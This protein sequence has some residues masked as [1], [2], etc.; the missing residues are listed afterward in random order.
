MN[1]EMTRK[2]AAIWQHSGDALVLADVE[3]QRILDANP[4]AE[5]LFGYSC[6]Q[7]QN[8]CVRDIHPADRLHEVMAAF[9]EG[10]ANPGHFIDLEIRRSDGTRV[11]V[12]INTGTFVGDDGRLIGIG[13][14][15]DI[16]ERLRAEHGVQR[17]N[18]ALT[19]INRAA[20][21]V[22]T[23][24][25]ETEMMRQ[26]CAALTDDVFVLSW[27]ALAKDNP[28]APVTIA[29]K[30]GTALGYLDGIEISWGGQA[31]GRGPTGRAIREAKTQVN[32][33]ALSN[34]AFSPWA[35]RARCHDIKSS[36]A[37]PLIRN[38]KAV[39]ALTVYSNQV[40]AFMPDVVGLFEDLARELVVGL[41]AKSHWAA[42]EAEFKSNLAHTARNRAAL[43]QMVAALA[44]TI[45]KRDPYTA[46]HQKRVCSLA[47]DVARKLG[48]DSGRCHAVYLAGLVHDIG[49][50][51]IP[52]EILNKPGK[53][54]AVEFEL[55]KLHAMTG[56]EI[57]SGIDFPWRLAEITRQ[58]HE[59]LDG[60]GYPDGLKGSEI[61]PEAQIIAVA[62]VFEAMSSH[63]PYRPAL[64]RDVAFAELR[65][66]REGQLTP[67]IVDIALE[68]FQQ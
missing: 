57:L 39:G 8:L 13:S 22:A 58:H 30:A 16:S 1:G 20:L 59:R 3:T 31:S 55:V 48:W 56:F 33:D 36:M 49:K 7:L 23:A 29:A 52:S 38:N 46:G 37:T 25:T 40:S 42:Y 5:A 10:T 62:D 41:D 17:L 35:D 61:L 68:V 12:E 21:A 43:E 4:R 63:R 19:A 67:E 64:G 28:E 44:S 11:P 53:L 2:L 6:K 51:N 15:R 32:N 24:E 26:L 66:L 45:E 9:A 14:F 50:I 47:L 27:I 60:S 54:L 65:R 18:W 34:P